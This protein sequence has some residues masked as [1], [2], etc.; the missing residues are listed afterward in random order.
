MGIDQRRYTA[1]N[2]EERRGVIVSLDERRRRMDAIERLMVAGVSANKIED[3]CKKEFSIGKTRVRGYMADIRN[4]W[5]EEERANRP[6]YK[7]QAMRR[8]YGHIA[9]ARKAGNWTSVAQFE[10][11]LTEIQ[12]TREPV[13][14]QLNVDA[15][16]T[17]AVLHVVANLT[18][19][20]RAAILAEQ[21]RLRGL[22]VG[23]VVDTK[24]EAVPEGAPPGGS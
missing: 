17:E 4:R 16:V 9:E 11:L 8:I 15:T 10:R 14:I 23:P 1:A 2:E 20:R 12:G 19:E 6:T 3:A 13:E 7:A 18:P 22:P 24:G 21:K 5:I